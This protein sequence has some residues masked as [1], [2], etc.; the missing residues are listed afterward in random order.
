MYIFLSFLTLCS[1]SS[2]LTRSV[3]FVFS[4]LFPL[5]VLICLTKMCCI[6]IGPQQAWRATRVWTYRTIW[7]A[8]G[9]QSIDPAHKV[10]KQYSI[11]HVVCMLFCHLQTRH[12]LWVSKANV[13]SQYLY[14][15]CT[16]ICLQR[17]TSTQTS[18]I[19][20]CIRPRAAIYTT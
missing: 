5:Y 14:Y 3:Q 7:C 10:R 4:I 2:F 16:V 20:N 19:I 15:I 9:L 1:T 17:D 8:I 6:L 18:V 13:S 12:E 11:N